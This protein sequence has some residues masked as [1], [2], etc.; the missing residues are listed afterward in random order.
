[1]VIILHHKI[2]NYKD[3]SKQIRKISEELEEL[4]EASLDYKYNNGY[5]YNIGN[6][7][8]DIIQACK[9]LLENEFTTDEIKEL[10]LKHN[11]KIKERL[12]T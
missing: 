2:K 11:N 8:F 9:T 3:M 1:M 12:E 6:E 7:L 10:Q 5:I 4:K